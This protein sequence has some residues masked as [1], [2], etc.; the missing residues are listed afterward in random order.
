[1]EYIS[2]RAGL[3]FVLLRNDMLAKSKSGFQSTSAILIVDTML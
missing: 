2:K 1:M 3:C